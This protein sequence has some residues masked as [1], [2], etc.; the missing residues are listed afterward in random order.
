MASRSQKRA[1]SVRPGAARTLPTTPRGKQKRARLVVAAR[2]VFQRDGYAGTRISDIT[3]E[4]DVAAGSFYTYFAD[5][6]EILRAVLEE[7]QEEM[8][9]PEIERVGGAD[10]PFEFSWSSPSCEKLFAAVS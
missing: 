1:A 4:A 7:L 5:K 8:L 9:H 3:I 6:E 10:T 2:A